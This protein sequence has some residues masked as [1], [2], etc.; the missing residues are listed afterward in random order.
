[1][2]KALRD[3]NLTPGDVNYINACGLGTKENDRIEAEAIRNLLG[4]RASSVCVSSMK[5]MIGHLGAGAGAV[6]MIGCILAMNNGVVPP[7]LNCDNPDDGFGLDFVP[8]KA[9]EAKIN[10]ALL[11]T[12]SFAGQNAAIAIKKLVD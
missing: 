7:T 1:M 11:N 10:V 4:D 12:A 5:S 6:E 8:N 2:L 9:R 3:G